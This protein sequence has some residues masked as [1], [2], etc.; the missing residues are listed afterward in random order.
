MS[1]SASRRPRRSPGQTA[2]W[3]W[4][5]SPTA[6]APCCSGKRHELHYESAARA[7]KVRRGSHGLGITQQVPELAKAYE[8]VRGAGLEI[9]REPVDEFYGDRV[10]MFLEAEGY[11]WT[12]S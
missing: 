4:P 3:P 6:R 9:L 2:S 11:E 1:H 7:R 12:I 10:F 5:F 8:V